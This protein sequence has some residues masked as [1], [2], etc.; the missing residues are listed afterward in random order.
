MP[1]GLGWKAH[2]SKPLAGFAHGSAGIALALSEGF[3]I[4]PKEIYQSTAQEALRYE[5]SVF[6]ETEGNWAD[7]RDLIMADP[8]HKNDENMVAWC[9]GAVGVG[10]S[11]LAL[12]DLR[13]DSLFDDEIRIALK[14]TLNKSFGD[15]HSLCHGDFGSLDFLL[16]LGKT[17]K[18]A[19]KTAYQITET[20]LPHIIENGCIGGV[21][22]AVENPGFMTGISGIGYQMLRLL[23][24]HVFPSVLLLK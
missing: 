6:V 18:N 15:N 9:N 14:T 5:R 24:P 10:L 20:L 11:R 2:G 19:L 4:I 13:Q 16:E 3:E 22:L 7:L 23:M 8:S 21:P 1:E 12:R 17:D